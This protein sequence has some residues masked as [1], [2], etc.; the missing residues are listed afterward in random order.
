MQSTSLAVDKHY[1][2]IQTIPLHV[3]YGLKTHQVSNVVK[4]EPTVTVSL[5]TSLQ[6][7]ALP[8]LPHK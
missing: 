1:W 7:L 5:D 6:Q 3:P 4:T 8:E 2:H